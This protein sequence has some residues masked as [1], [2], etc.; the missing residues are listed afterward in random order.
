MGFKFTHVDDDYVYEFEKLD[1]GTL[2]D[3]IVRKVITIPYVDMT[4][5]E[6][7]AYKEKCQN[8]QYQQIGTDNRGNVLL[9][10]V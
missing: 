10:S 2:I 7:K 5:S 9:R 1:D 4:D 8:A 3:G 6:L